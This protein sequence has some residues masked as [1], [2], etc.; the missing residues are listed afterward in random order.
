MRLLNVISLSREFF[1]FFLIVK[2]KFFF[3]LYGVA[4]L[5]KEKIKTNGK[6]KIDEPLQLSSFCQGPRVIGLRE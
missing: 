6:T 1:F 3:V 4:K 5:N 2:K